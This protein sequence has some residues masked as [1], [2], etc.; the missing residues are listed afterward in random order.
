MSGKRRPL[1]ALHR[2]A[3]LL[4]V[5][6]IVA[7]AR[8]RHAP[9]ADGFTGLKTRIETPLLDETARFYTDLLGLRVL[10]AWDEAGDRGV[11]LGLRDTRSGEAFLEIAHAAAAT[12]PVVSL[13]FRVRDLAAVEARLR[14]RWPYRGPERRPWGSTYLYLRDPAG[15]QVILYEG[16][17]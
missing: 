11:I 12:T 8:P 13:Q 7:C 17:L 16:D 3:L 1:A 9:L 4:A 14:G 5:V 10:D 15:V 2:C 6:C